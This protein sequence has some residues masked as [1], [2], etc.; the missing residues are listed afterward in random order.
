MLGPKPERC[1]QECASKHKM[2]DLGT[3]E[4][5]HETVRW[6][7]CRNLLFQTFIAD[8]GLELVGW[9][10]GRLRTHG[11]RPV[12]EVLETAAF[13]GSVAPPRKVPYFLTP[14]YALRQDNLEKN[15][16]AV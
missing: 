7:V 3:F 14:L 12:P 15:F 8:N 9:R 2:R 1:V 16:L 11:S 13:N 10:G 6:P 4:Q 5:M